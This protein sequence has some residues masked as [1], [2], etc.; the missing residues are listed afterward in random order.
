LGRPFREDDKALTGL[1]NAFGFIPV[2]HSAFGIN[3]LYAK[4]I[5]LW[6][7]F[8]GQMGDQEFE[9]LLMILILENPKNWNRNDPRQHDLVPR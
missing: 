4:D 6:R 1:T 7:G 9:H 5:A 8:G 3:L 2:L